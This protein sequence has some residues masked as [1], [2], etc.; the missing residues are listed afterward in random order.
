MERKD[1]VAF[2]KTFVKK[3][4]SEVNYGTYRE[5]T[6]SSL[7]NDGLGTRANSVWKQSQFIVAYWSNISETDDVS[8]YLKGWSE[9]TRGIFDQ[10]LLLE[11]PRNTWTVY[12]KHGN[13]MKLD[14]LK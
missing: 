4:K 3:Q 11:C 5:T 8:E 13:I 1:I 7:L 12:D 2:L 10:Y 6:R 9:L 14:D